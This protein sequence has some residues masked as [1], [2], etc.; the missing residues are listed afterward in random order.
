MTHIFSE[1]QL[2]KIQQ[3]HFH[4]FANYLNKSERSGKIGNV[5][6]KPSL[7]IAPHSVAP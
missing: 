2:G 6:G 4:S 3:L 5:T 7:Q 1:T